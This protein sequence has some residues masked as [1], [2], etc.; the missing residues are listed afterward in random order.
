[1]Y[2][3]I[4][5]VITPLQ[6]IGILIWYIVNEIINNEEEK[7]YKYSRASLIMVLTQVT[8]LPFV[9]DHVTPNHVVDFCCIDHSRFK[10]VDEAITVLFS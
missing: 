4:C 6:A 2:D 1:M 3:V 7:W 9:L 10:L 8:S 5:S